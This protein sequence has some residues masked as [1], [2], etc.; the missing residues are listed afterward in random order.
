MT[1][2]QQ[3][4]SPAVVGICWLIGN[5]LKSSVPKLPNNYIPLALGLIG[6]ILMTI[7]NGFSGLNLIIGVVS[8]LSATGVHQV[9]KGFSKEEEKLKNDNEQRYPGGN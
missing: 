7:L 4:I 8:G 3:F 6:A 9:Y 2:L 1:E 5:T